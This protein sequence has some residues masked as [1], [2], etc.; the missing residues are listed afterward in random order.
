MLSLYPNPTSGTL[1]LV[2]HDASG[3]KQVSVFDQSGK[4]IFREQRVMVNGVAQQLDL[5]S[6]AA[7]SYHIQIVGQQT[8]A[9][10][11]VILQK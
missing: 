5:S 3:I 10:V 2:S 7:G 1:T 6:L 11:S 8:V 9:N 4:M